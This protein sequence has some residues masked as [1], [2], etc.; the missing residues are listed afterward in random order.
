MEENLSSALIMEDDVDW[1]IRIKSQLQKIALGTTALTQPKISNRT[2]YLDPSYPESTGHDSHTEVFITSEQNPPIH[3][4]EASPY[5]DSWDLL[6]LGHCGMRTPTPDDNNK[7]GIPLGRAVITPD[8][9]VPEKQYLPMRFENTEWQRDLESYPPHTRIVTRAMGGIC[10]LAYAVSQQG[11]RKLLYE[12]S[13]NR[14]DA[15]Y[16]LALMGTCENNRDTHFTCLGVLPA[17]FQHHRPAGPMHSYSDID[18]A[19]HDVNQRAY[20]RDI[21]WSTRLNMQKLVSGDTDYIDQYPDGK[22][23]FLN[24][25][26]W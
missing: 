18:D 22:E 20:T 21:R 12:L 3:A 23:L 26:Q 17:V 5:G 16:D 1:D 7:K 2:E 8:E 6:W 25:H 4:P 14:L 19:G 11:A 10:T 15:P 9:T 24:D 13:L